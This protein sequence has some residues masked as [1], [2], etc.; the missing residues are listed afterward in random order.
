M[1]E[2]AVKRKTENKVRCRRKSQWEK[3]KSEARRTQS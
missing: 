2:Y 1:V 3:R